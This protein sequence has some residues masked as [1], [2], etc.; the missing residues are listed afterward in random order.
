MKKIFITLVLF[1]WFL[2]YL[3]FA[4]GE[5]EYLISKNNLIE[6]SVYNE[7]DLSKTVRVSARGTITYPLLGEVSAE[8]LTA[9]EFEE[10]L[11]KLLERDYLVS[12]QVNVFVKEYSKISILGQVKNPG[13]YELKS[14]IT[15]LEAIALAGGFTELADYN[16]IS[17]TRRDDS[18]GKDNLI[19]SASEFS[20]ESNRVIDLYAHPD[21]VI[22][23]PELGFISVVGQV[24]SPGRFSLKV[25]MTAIEAIALAGGLTDIAAPNATKV[26]RVSGGKKII[27]N[28]PVASILKGGDKSKD[29]P[30]KLGDTIVVP[31]S[32]F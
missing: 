25:G 28:V 10:K 26:I 30:L 14:G 20:G 24:K 22:T 12:P 13:Y 31:E 17:V 27:F 18:G 9:K 16:K 8:G 29:V 5:K 32:F 15:I 3:T 1:S 2:P 11:T 21:D 23:V 7:P 4:Q 19:V 6:I